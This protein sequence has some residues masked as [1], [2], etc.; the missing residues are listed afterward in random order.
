M[1][2][3]LKLL[4]ASIVI[5]G[6]LLLI[7]LVV[8]FWCYRRFCGLDSRFY[9]P[10]G[11]TVVRLVIYRSFEMPVSFTVIE[12]G[13]VARVET[14][15][16]TGPDRRQHWHRGCWRG[17]SLTSAEWAQVQALLAQADMRVLASEH[18]PLFNDGSTWHLSV[19]TTTGLE[20]VTRHCPDGFLGN[21]RY[22]ALCALG[23]LLDAA[24]G[25][26][27]PSE[28]LVSEPSEE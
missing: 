17:R 6:V 10:R 28:E 23:L 8:G 7:L 18:Q 21:H 3:F 26:P 25:W 13:G 19:R 24:A 22:K 15:L 1:K 20:T 14:F 5:S 4:R 12:R 11:T 9:H 27:I 2:S 16:A